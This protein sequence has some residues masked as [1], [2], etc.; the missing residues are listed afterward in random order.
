MP[1]PACQSGHAII[2]GFGVPGRIVA[3]ILESRGT[4]YT[5]IETNPATVNRVEKSG[6]R[7]VCGDVSDPA[8][9]R[10]AGIETA[11]LLIIAIPNQAA[12]LLATRQARQLNPSIRIITRTHFTSAGM[13]ARQLGADAVVVAEQAV[14]KEFAHLLSNNIDA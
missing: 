7:L 5:V 10:S 1:D 6:R 8:I 14:A 2:A 4:P 12:A 9:L 3:E 11:T 13:E